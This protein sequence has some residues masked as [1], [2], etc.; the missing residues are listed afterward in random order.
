VPYISGARFIAVFQVEEISTTGARSLGA[1]AS[2]T[3][4]DGK[5]Y[6]VASCAIDSSPFTF[7]SS[8]RHVPITGEYI[9]AINLYSSKT[10]GSEQPAGFNRRL[11]QFTTVSQDTAVANIGIALLGGVLG[12]IATLFFTNVLS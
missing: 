2:L 9:L 8:V 4:P 1:V 11:M 10:D 5:S 6:Q 7:Q 12:S 3:E